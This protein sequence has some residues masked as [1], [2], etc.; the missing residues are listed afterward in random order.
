[1]SVFKGSQLEVDRKEITGSFLFNT[2]RIA[3]L[4]VDGSD[5]Q[6]L[7]TKNYLEPKNPAHEYKL[8]ETN[9]TI[10]ALYGGDD[11][12]VSLPVLKKKVNGV[13][14]SFAKTV[15]IGVD[16]IAYGW[17]DPDNAALSWIECYPNGFKKVLYQV[18]LSLDQINGLNNILTFKFLDSL[19]SAFVGGDRTGTINY[20][21]GSIAISV[22]N[23]TVVTALVGSWTVNS[24]CVVKVGATEQVSG[25]TQNNFTNPVVFTVENPAGQIKSFTVTVTIL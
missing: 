19:N 20:S 10:T 16:K 21:T 1:M 12:V 22:P 13:V 11:T 17:A 14:S 5:S 8:D 25:T 9:A 7:Y 15:A 4:T 6:M 24:D 2:N 18:N 3:E 23:A